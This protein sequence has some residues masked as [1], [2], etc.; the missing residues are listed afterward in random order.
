MKK[1]I[2]SIILTTSLFCISNSLFSKPVVVFDIHGVLLKEDLATLIKKQIAALMQ[3]RR[4]LKNNQYYQLLCD[5]METHRPL[6]APTASY[7]ED[8]GIPYEVFA[9]FSGLKEP[10]EV[11]QAL[12]TMV[13]SVG[14]DEQSQ[15]ILT[16]LLNTLFEDEIRI[17]RLTPIPSGIALFNACLASPNL[18][19]C[20]YSNAPSEWVSQYKT[21]FPDVFAHI[22][23]ERIFCSGATG[24]VKPSPDVLTFIAQQ[25]DCSI[26]DII[27]I[28][29]S[30]NNC[31]A[32]HT[33][34]ATGIHFFT[35]ITPPAN[36]ASTN[37]TP[38]E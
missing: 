4:S 18:D 14:L 36:V 6:G 3:T 23:Q 16:A 11:Y 22:S 38:I 29:D 31:N 2:S 7:S 27:L 17:S 15:L 8:Y 30:S 28:D 32:A 21:I 34:G 35:P 5:L 26:S 9:L 25:A 37:D 12:L 10:Q 33:A 1:C 24:L 20:I 13:Q 19:V